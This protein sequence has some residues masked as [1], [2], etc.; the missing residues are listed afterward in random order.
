MLFSRRQ[1][2]TA[3]LAAG[4]ALA[5]VRLVHGPF[6][7]G[8][9]AAPAAGFAF[10]GNDEHVILGAIAPVV[11][12]GALPAAG[13]ERTAALDRTVRAVDAA[14]AGFLPAVQEEV[15]EL[16]ALLA[17]APARRFLAGVSRPW[18]EADPVSVAAFLE[19]W[20]NSRFA[21]LRSAYS[22]LRQLILA[23]WYGQTEAWGAIGY[24]GP[25]ALDT[26]KR[27]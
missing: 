27:S 11:L 4:A 25:P 17:F 8:N 12:A 24:G 3:G 23:A 6:G 13:A 1:F 22:A 7:E 18:A 15:H 10:L 16:F 19:G 20:R 2:L 9:A 21:L 14:I 5:A 26:A